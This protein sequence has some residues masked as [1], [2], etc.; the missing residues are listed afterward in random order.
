MSVTACYSSAV[1]FL[2]LSSGLIDHA[3][4]A[5]AAATPELG[6][7]PSTSSA[8]KSLTKT[9]TVTDVIAYV[10][11]TTTTLQSAS[12]QG[13]YYYVGIN[14]TT[15]FYEGKSPVTG[16]S[17][18][19]QTSTVMVS[20]LPAGEGGGSSGSDE[21]MTTIQSTVTVTVKST[22]TQIIS[23]LSSSKPGRTFTGS[24]QRGWNVTATMTKGVAIGGAVGSRSGYSNP[25]TEGTASV[26]VKTS[27]PGS[28]ATAA[29]AS[30][31]SGWKTTYRVKVG[32]V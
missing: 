20:P 9:S 23:F 29:P 6:T 4:L 2:D 30:G 16:T 12:G 25:G 1:G 11:S 5:T 7:S 10:D 26:V 14:G 28:L 27:L 13:P 17:L 18:V 21:S 32:S 8:P 19:T 3:V 22:L 15:V 24:G 31:P